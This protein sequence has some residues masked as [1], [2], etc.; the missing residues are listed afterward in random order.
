MTRTLRAL[1]CLATDK[2]ERRLG[3][4]YQLGHEPFG[5]RRAPTVLCGKGG[6]G[7]RWCVPIAL[8]VDADLRPAVRGGGI[9]CFRAAHP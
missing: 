2:P 6:L 1:A 5:D 4:P 3:K 8:G 7:A 9:R